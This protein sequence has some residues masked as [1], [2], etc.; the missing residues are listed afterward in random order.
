MSGQEA[1]GTAPGRARRGREGATRVLRTGV[2]GRKPG[3][4]RW[5]PHG[6][7][8]R[9]A[10]ARKPGVTRNFSM[11]QR[12]KNRPAAGGRRAFVGVRGSGGKDRE[13]RG[14]GPRGAAGA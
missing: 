7:R 2:L 8:P 11:L 6:W 10:D 9:G 5:I 12:D 3:I 1:A 13:V 14:P 4:L